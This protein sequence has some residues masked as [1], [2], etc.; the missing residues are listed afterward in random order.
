MRTCYAFREKMYSLIANIHLRN[1]FIRLAI[2][3]WIFAYYW[4]GV[5]SNRGEEMTEMKYKALSAKGYALICMPAKA[6]R[7]ELA[8]EK[9][10]FNRTSLP[11]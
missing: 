3:A 7:W 6:G 5:N 9:N 2:F 8:Y 4:K 1:E 10:C 11:V